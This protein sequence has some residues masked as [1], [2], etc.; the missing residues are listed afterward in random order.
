MTVAIPSRPGV[1]RLAISSIPFGDRRSCAQ[2]RRSTDREWEGA[3]I[4][5]GV[6][7]CR[8]VKRSLTILGLFV[9][10]SVGAPCQP[11]QQPAPPASA[12]SPAQEQEPGFVIRMETKL[13][14][15]NFYVAQKNRYVDN[16]RPEDIQLLEDGKPQKLAVFEGPG[17]GRRNTPVEILLLFDVSLSVMNI[18]LLS[19]FAI[20]ETLLDG[21][22]EH[23]SV[24]IY[25]FGS[26]WRRFVEPTRDMN[27]LQA[28]LEAVFDFTN[29]G[30]RLYESIIYTARDAAESGSNASRVM[31]IFSDSFSTTRM[32]PKDAA[33]MAN[34]YGIPLYPVIL[35]HQ[36]VMRRAMGGGGFGGGGGRGVPNVNTLDR[37]AVAKDQEAQMLEFAELGELTGGRSYDPPVVNSIIVREIMRSVATHVQMQYVAGYYPASSGEKRTHK[38]EVKLLRKDA[39]KLRGG[40]RTVLH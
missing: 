35:G 3:G 12:P 21:I 18:D 29:P 25:A 38:L 13:A 6:L 34:Y 16:L 22:G 36:R 28:A 8:L 33:R 4:T 1:I 20:K 14:L 2:S 17:T 15:V 5:A 27:K 30:T 11:G 9:C 10:L 24:S 31:V 40:T 23:V 39:G 26:K 32:P 37:Q 19:P 7:R